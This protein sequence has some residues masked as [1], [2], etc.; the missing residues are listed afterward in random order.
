VR[1]RVEERLADVD[2]NH[3]PVVQVLV[4]P[5]SGDKYV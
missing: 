2:D 4:E 3:V 1:L 5:R